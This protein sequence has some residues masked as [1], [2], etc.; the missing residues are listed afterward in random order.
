MYDE[1]KKYFVLDR[2]GQ[3]RQDKKIMY[4]HNDSN[5][6]TK[7]GPLSNVLFESPFASVSTVS[8]GHP[9]PV[10]LAT[11]SAP[12]FKVLAPFSYPHQNEQG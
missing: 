1:K 8:G 6:P 3:P 11:P 9:S 7:E 4:P 12:E 2:Q 5:K 10:S